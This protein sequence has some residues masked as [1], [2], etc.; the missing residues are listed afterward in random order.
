MRSGTILSILG[1]LLF[2]LGLIL[3]VPMGLSLFYQDSSWVAFLAS[4]GIGILVG[5]GLA[6][7]FRPDQEI[8]HRE[9]FCIVAL[10]WILAAALGALPY[11]FSGKIPNYI[12]AYFEAMSGFTTTGSTILE[13]VEILTKSL[14]FWRALTHW[15]GGMGIIILSLAILPVLGVG[16]MQLFKAEMPGPTKDRLAPRIQDTARILWGV[17][18][19]LTLIEVLLLMLA[20]MDLFDATC[21]AFA[22]MATGGFSTK[23]A[24]VGGYDSAAIDYIII[25]FMI[26]AGMNFTIHFR[27]LQGK[28]VRSLKN[29]ELRL[30][31]VV[32]FGATALIFITNWWYGQYDDPLQNIRYSMFQA[33]SILTTTGFGTADFD[34]WAPCAKTVLVTLMLLGGMA[35]STGGGIKHV[36][37]LI[38]MKF[39]RVQIKK[40]IHPMAVEAIKLDGKKIPQDV[41]QS[42]LGFL[43]LYMAVG[44]TATIVVT[45]T[46]VDIVTGSTSVIA[47]LNNIGPGLGGVGPAKNFADLPYVAK[48]VLTLC[49][50]AGRLELYTIALLFVPEYWKDMRRPKTRWSSLP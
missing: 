14:L 42:I 46:G 25:V 13:E 30:Y 10:S 16:G 49:M 37:A 8:G 34:T 11:F 31:M 6:F 17:Y 5:G 22:T 44:I 29:E 45:L 19:L 38:F 9:G 15:L 39:T 50:V 36:R 24:S 12:D 1:W 28:V 18:V 23:T 2:F 47:T 4:S 20:G 7:T 40:L 27:I 32:G 33:W 43:S 48:V 35:G 26:L 3:L 21:H 41:V